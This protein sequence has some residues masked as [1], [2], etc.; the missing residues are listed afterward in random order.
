MIR[1]Y[2]IEYWFVTDF[3]KIQWELLR[4]IAIGQPFTNEDNRLMRIS[5]LQKTLLLHSA[6]STHR[7][8]RRFSQTPAPATQFQTSPGGLDLCFPPQRT[9]GGDVS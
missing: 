1:T 8:T 7:Q 6:T 3:R 9:V 4:K 2:C 5:N